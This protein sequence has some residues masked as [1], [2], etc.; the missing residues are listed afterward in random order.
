MNDNKAVNELVDII[1]DIVKQEIASLD[2]TVLCQVK[3]KVSDDHYDLIIFPDEDVI[4]KNIVNMTKFDLNPG[5]YVY[6]YKINNQISTSFI[7]YKV[8]PLLKDVS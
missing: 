3:R 8:T 7:C 6:V 5:D 1:R 4:I 2:K